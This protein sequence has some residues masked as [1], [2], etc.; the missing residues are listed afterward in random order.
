MEKMGR[1]A[2][3]YGLNYAVKGFA[4]YLVYNEYQQYSHLYDTTVVTM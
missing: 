1:H 3:C 4:A 2:R